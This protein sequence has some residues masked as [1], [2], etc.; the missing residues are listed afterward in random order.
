MNRIITTIILCFVAIVATAQNKTGIKVEY[1]Y[2]FFTV[3]GYEVNRAMILTSSNTKSKFYNSDTNR[4]DSICNTPEG[5]AEFEAY[6]NSV[7]DKQQNRLTR[8]EKMFVEKN[9][10]TNEMTVYDTVAGED[11]YYYNESLGGINWVMKDS[12]ERI[13]GYDCQ[14]AECDY[15]GRHWKVWFTQ[16]I[17]IP[18]GPWKLNG[19]PGLILKAKEDAGQYE[20][21]AVGI[22]SYE[23]E[24]EPV[25]QKDLYSRIDRKELLQ[26]KRLIDENMGGFISAR[27]GVNL[28]NN[29]SSLRTNKDIDY[30]ETDYR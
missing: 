22:E 17:P 11:R 29:M 14:M 3:R 24:I 6:Y 19:L 10:E 23:G 15:H 25:Y 28:P 2:H 4:I 5:K 7:S 9:R 16:D 18:D 12:T 1:N 13:L 8:W 30:L 26:T 20:F 21:T 27:T